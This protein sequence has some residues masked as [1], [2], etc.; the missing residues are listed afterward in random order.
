[1]AMLASNGF[2]WMATVISSL[3]IGNA[4]TY[5]MTASGADSRTGDHQRI[6]RLNHGRL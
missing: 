6:R 4:T 5:L 1:M 3:F 2:A